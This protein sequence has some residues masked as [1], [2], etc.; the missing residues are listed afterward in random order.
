MSISRM[1]NEQDQRISRVEESMDS[2]ARS[3]DLLR[4]ELRAHE[5]QCSRY[6]KDQTTLNA[7]LRGFMRAAKWL[8]GT[9]L[10]AILGVGG[11]LIEH[12]LGAI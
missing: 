9:I 3:V 8:G 1:D 4:D 2:L 12:F 7:E 5:K 10:T 11:L 6:W